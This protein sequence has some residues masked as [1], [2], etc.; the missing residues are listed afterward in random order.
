[1][2]QYL[3]IFFLLAI[4]RASPLVKGCF[5]ACK[6]F[7]AG[8]VAACIWGQNKQKKYIEVYYH[9]RYEWWGSE[10][11]LHRIYISQTN[12]SVPVCPRSFSVLKEVG[13]LLLADGG[14]RPG[15]ALWIPDGMLLNRGL[16]KPGLGCLDPN[17]STGESVDSGYCVHTHLPFRGLCT[18][19]C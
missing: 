7:V 13:A 14:L 6:I 5:F 4:G 17:V 8:T 19:C 3:P 9:L 18:V 15:A 16:G 10:I 1:M 11:K 12:V 2:S